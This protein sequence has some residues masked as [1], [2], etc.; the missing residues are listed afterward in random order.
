M[1][2]TDCIDFLQWALPRLHLRWPGFRKVRR[3]VCRRIQRRTG[4]LGLG[5]PGEY[6][7]YLERH[8]EEW[9]ILDGLT[10]ITISSFYRDRAVWDFLRNDVLPVLG[11]QGAGA[12][13][14]WSVG[15]ASGEEPYTL[16]LA[17]RL[18]TALQRPLAD[19]EIVATDVH[20]H[21]LRRAR[22][23]CYEPGSLK[24][25][26]EGWLE[27]AFDQQGE[28]YCLREAYR[29]GIE[30]RRQDIREDL[31]VESFDLILCRNLVLTYFDDALARSTLG[32]IRSRLR[33]GGAFVAGRRETLPSG[34]WGLTAWDGAGGLG[35]YRGVREQDKAYL[36]QESCRFLPYN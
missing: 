14:A 29:A 30:F 10:P 33:E 28:K 26:P 25:L 19:L 17:W 31:P 6:R 8:P 23:A 11:G 16:M 9:E 1:K 7:E 12:L 32:R 18:C 2:D 35:I 34:H 4:D 22:A 3:Q 13:R 5:S 15:C 20:P 36:D 24:H 21:V 27:R